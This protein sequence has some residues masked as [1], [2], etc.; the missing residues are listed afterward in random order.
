M[1]KILA[2]VLVLLMITASFSACNGNSPDTASTQA[3]TAAGTE[4]GAKETGAETEEIPA[5]PAS[6]QVVSLRVNYEKEPNCIDDTP[7][8][9][10]ATESTVRGTY[11][12]SYRI[13][14]AKS[15]AALRSGDFVWDSGEVQSDVSVN[16]KY[17]GVLEASHRYFWR[18]TVTTGSGEKLVSA[19]SSFETGLRGEAFK[20]ASWIRQSVSGSLSGANWI[21][22]YGGQEHGKIEPGTQYF[23]Y[24]FDIKDESRIVSATLSFTADDYGKLYLN[25][26]TVIDK[27]N[28]TD[29]WQSGVCVDVTD[30]LSEHNVIAAYAGNTG[31]GYAGIIARLAVTFDD[32]TSDVM[33]TDASWKFSETGPDGWEQPGFD[34][35]GW[36]RPDTAIIYSSA[37]W[38]NNVTFASSEG[39]SAPMLRYEFQADKKIAEARLFATAAGLYV[40]YI[41]GSKVGDTALDPG[42]SEYQVRVMYQSYDVTSLLHEGKNAIAAMLG[43][44]WYIG[45]YSPYGGTIPAFLCKLVIDYEDGSRQTVCTD[46]NWKVYTGGPITYNDIFN[47][48]TYDARKEQDG[49]TSVGF[50][51]SRWQNAAV[52]TSAELGIGEITAQLSGQ[53]KVMDKVQAKERTN[54][55]K[56]V[57]I[58]DF[59]QNLTGVVSITVKGKKGVTVKMRH[60]EMLNDGNAGSDGA[61]GTLYTTNLRSAEATDRYTLKGDANGETYT[62]SFTY[63]GF[64]YL[65]RSFRTARLQR[66]HR[67]RFILRYGRYGQ[68]SDVGRSDK[69]AH[70]EYVLGTARQFLVKSHRLPAARRAHGLVRRRADLLRHGGLQYER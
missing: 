55:E 34:D 10:W 4:T 1:K 27:R 45:A 41:N 38:S 13:T 7:V 67:A 51:D 52:V 42:K 18:V 14:V 46:G 59:G 25:G 26:E 31:V 30:R 23:R 21:W 57:Y 33:V 11:Q 44:G 37:P 28:V 12:K 3:Q 47:G 19:V 43:R 69:S 36:G 8:F 54:P 22:N 66:R 15:E 61:A 29:A 70:L 2:A 20:D 9:S 48:E 6:G 35:S 49:W 64:R 16:I 32:G 5:G 17:G 60:G 63:H 40:P 65:D 56:G 62:P 53:V 68:H 58:Y 50:D 39:S 24:K